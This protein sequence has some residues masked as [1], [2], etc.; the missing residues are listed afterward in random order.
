MVNT[1][2]RKFNEGLEFKFSRK[3]LLFAFCILQLSTTLGI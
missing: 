3:Y 1:A 2:K